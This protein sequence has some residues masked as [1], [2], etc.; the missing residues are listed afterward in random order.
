ML[1]RIKNIYHLYQSL[2]GNIYY[3]F[4]SKKLTVI[5]VTGTSG[6]TTTTLMIY[7][8]LRKAGY[9]VSVLTTVKA[10]I[11]GRE[12]DTGFHVTTPDPHILPRYIQQAVKHGDTHFIL[13]VSSHALDQNRVAFIPFKIG[14][15]TTLAHEHLDYHKTF[16]NYARAKFKLLHMSENAVLPVHLLNGQ[17]REAVMYDKLIGKMRTYGLKDGDETQDKWHFSL[18]M[19]GDYNIMNALAAATVASILKID[20]KKI[21]DSL[22]L[23]TGIPGR[24]EEIP[25][26]RGFKIIIDF[27]HKPDALEAVLNVARQM[28]NKKNNSDKISKSK[29]IVLYGCA[30][31]RDFLKR[32]IMG[33]ISGTLADASILSDED[34]RYE[35]RMKIINE[36]ATG[37]LE[38]GAQEVNASQFVKNDSKHIFVKIPDRQEAINFVINTMAKKGDIILF[39]GKGHEQSMNYRGIEQPW[40]EHAAVQK[41]LDLEDHD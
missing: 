16:T 17:L 13:E 33:K 27:A 35:D 22:N 38:S 2:I 29:V 8:V 20:I 18:K 12:F 9:K 26:K 37:C 5:G 30:S 25:N 1:Q 39:C 15:L 34:P 7:E 36:I 6:K 14:V 40:S 21:K 28:I 24:F 3:G 32:P 4:P 41:A 10:I 11:G 31:E 23:F 19:P